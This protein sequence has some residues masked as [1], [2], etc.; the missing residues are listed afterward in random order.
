MSTG[1]AASARTSPGALVLPR[2]AWWARGPHAQTLWG[3]YGRAKDLVDFEREVLTSPDGEDIVLDHVT[4]LASSPRVLLLH[5]LEGS[6]QAVYIQGLA[7]AHAQKGIRKKA[8][9]FS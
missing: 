3:R 2:P 1:L 5:G 6:S 7:R 9:N 4:G 8:Q